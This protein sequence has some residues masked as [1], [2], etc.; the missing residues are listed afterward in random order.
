[1]AYRRSNDHGWT[2]EY[3]SR[4]SLELTGYLPENLTG[5]CRVAFKDLILREQLGCVE[6]AW[7]KCRGNSGIFRAEYPLV[8]ASG[9]FKWVHDEGHAVFSENGEIIALEGYLTDISGIEQIQKSLQLA[10]KKI[11]ILSSATRHDINNKLTILVGY[12]QLIGMDAT[13]PQVIEYAAI[14][15][16]AVEDISVILKFSRDYEKLG[17]KSPEWQDVR[18]AINDEASL[19]KLECVKFDNRI[20]GIWIY[21]DLLLG[22]VFFNIIENAVRHGKS[23]TLFRAWSERRGKDLYLIFEDDGIG[24]PPERK[25]KIFEFGA[26]NKSGYGL[27]L[28]REILA[29]TGIRIEERGEP[30]EGARF[31]IQVPEGRFREME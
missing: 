30:G 22:R 4:G 10:N 13:D 11:D 5:T 31:E 29:V 7:E 16:K 19:K 20:A 18:S 1:M 9:T 27:F 2:L 17:F 28:I 12:L 26:G 24:I 23:L 3:V 15:A 8:T 21:A 6:D 25:E 14:L